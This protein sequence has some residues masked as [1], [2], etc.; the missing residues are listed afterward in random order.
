MEIPDGPE[1]M[2]PEWLTQALHSGGAITS[3]TVLSFQAQAVGAEGAE[4]TGQM[5]RVIPVYDAQEPSAPRSLIAKF[6]AR[7][8]QTRAGVNSLGMYA[9]EFRFYHQEAGKVGLA[10]PRCYYGDYHESDTTILLLED[11]AP[12]E[13]VGPD[14]NPAQ[15]ELV[16]QGMARFHAYW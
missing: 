7:D 15:L 14:L 6:H 12:A 1:F 8:M 13:S 3:A 11:L 16:I 2:T 9:N 5:A 10:T 4:I